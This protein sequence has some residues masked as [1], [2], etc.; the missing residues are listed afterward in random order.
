M[1]RYIKSLG[2]EPVWS[3][4]GSFDEEL[5]KQIDPASEFQSAVGKYSIDELALKLREAEALVTVDS[6]I[7]HLAKLTETKTLVLLGGSS[8][9]R[10]APCDFYSQRNMY[11]VASDFNCPNKK[12][13]S[14]HCQ[15]N[16]LK[17]CPY[18]DGIVSDCMKGL[19]VEKVKSAV[20]DMLKQSK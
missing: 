17:N 10:I 2:F 19:S 12:S 4:S 16:L 1:A 15:K 8:F 5:L 3:G 18:N 9:E 7:F 13:A 6:G 11:F 14:Y 20:F